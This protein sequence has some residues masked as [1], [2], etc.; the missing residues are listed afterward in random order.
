MALFLYSV[1]ESWNTRVYTIEECREG[2]DA[3]FAKLG[4]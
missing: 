3:D 2:Y 4:I 1:D